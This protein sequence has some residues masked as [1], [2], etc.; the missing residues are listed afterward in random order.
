MFER[1]V[2]LSV[3]WIESM[4]MVLRAFAA[5]DVGADLHLRAK[6]RQVVKSVIGMNMRVIENRSIDVKI[7]IREQKGMN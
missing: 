2:G 6:A 3:A 7:L 4:A 1:I 5:L